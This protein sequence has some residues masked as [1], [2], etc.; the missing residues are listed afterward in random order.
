VNPPARIWVASRRLPMMH[1]QGYCGPRAPS[2]QTFAWFIWRQESRTA[3]EIGWF[4]W[5]EF[6]SSPA[7]LSG[8]VVG[9]AK[10]S[11]SLEGNEADIPS[12]TLKFRAAEAARKKAARNEAAAKFSNINGAK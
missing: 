2:N 6:S 3:P 10:K 4:D 1:R 9:R 11:P 5:Q 12:A 7:K 8:G